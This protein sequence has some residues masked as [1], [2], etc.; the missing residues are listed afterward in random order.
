MLNKISTSK[1]KAAITIEVT[2]SVALSIL[3]LFLAL[4]LF[5]D[6]LATMAANSGIQNLFNRSNQTAKTYYSKQNVDPTK[7]AV[8]M[9][10]SQINVQIAGD[11]GSTNTKTPPTLAQYLKQAQDIID[12]YKTTPPTDQ[13]QMEELARAELAKFIDSGSISSDDISTCKTNKIA[14][15][16][17]SDGEF[18]AITSTNGTKTLLIE[19][20]GNN[21]ADELSIIKDVFNKSFN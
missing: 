21:T 14:V 16:R 6:N 3:V 12:K 5:S 15:L 8:N 13:S 9:N 11:Q 10:T 1:K 4:G 20:S 19:N 17:L 2:L 18:K 7:T